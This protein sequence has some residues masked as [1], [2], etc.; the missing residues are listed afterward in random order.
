MNDILQYEFFDNTLQAYI[1]CFGSIMLVILLKRILS[2]FVSRILFRLIKHSSWK[3]DQKS[4]VE[5][6]FQPMQVFLVVTITMIALDKLKFPRQI[7]FEIYHIS[8][9]RII[10]SIA[11][12]IFVI[13]FIWLLR[14]IIDFVALLMEQKAN[15]T[16][17]QADNQ[18]VVFFKDF[19]K[20][21]L[22]IAGILLVIRF[23]FNKDI[24]TYLAGLSIV[25]GALAL[26]ARES[27]EN[28]IASF[29]IFFDK[30]FHVGDLV[31]VQSI[32]GTIEKIGLRS[33]RLR[34]DQKTFVTVPNK[35]MV[36]SIMDNLTLR[37]Q[38]RGDLK[39][40]LSL[41]TSSVKL[42]HTIAGIRTI[43]AHPAMESYVAFL[44]DIT[45]NAFIIHV[46]YYTAILPI[47]EFNQLKQT[48]NLEVLRLL[49][50]LQVELAGEVKEVVVK[51][52]RTD[53]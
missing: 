31:K 11:K 9:R 53:R 45:A 18:M 26:A 51:E 24:T 25:A 32:T 2:R 48:I 8:F 42:D 40:E 49:E 37:T 33:T 5:L 21:I 34:T 44:N 13:T 39:L 36:D 43:L 4:F 50:S 38:R 27:L 52:V 35:Q 23:S 12:G 19:F 47:A 16:A 14:R 6:V 10:D 41:Q 46:E 22:V 30:P 7:D 15:L 1:I 28:L 17:D 3:I 29:I 20:A